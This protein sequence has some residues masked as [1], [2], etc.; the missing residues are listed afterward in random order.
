MNSG[1]KRQL[2][3]IG[4]ASMILVL[5]C[6]G[7]PSATT[8]GPEET[9]AVV[10]QPAGP[11]KADLVAL[12]KAKE[13]LDTAR[14]IVQDFNGP[15]YFPSEWE[16]A[17]AGY[18]G[19]PLTQEPATQDEARDL[20]NKINAVVQV[21]RSLADKTVKQYFQDA[22]G[23]T[24]TTFRALVEGGVLTMGPDLLKP[25]STLTAEARA[26]YQAGEAGDDKSY[27]SAKASYDKALEIYSVL[28]TGVAA[29]KVR[30]A[31]INL[32]LQ[33]AVRE[34]ALLEYTPV[35]LDIADA[36]GL[37]AIERYEGEDYPAAR[38]LAF[39]A[40]K[41]YEIIGTG[42][43][44]YKERLADI[45]EGI[46]RIAP[47]YL[48][49]V[50][51]KGIEG[52]AAFESG[53]EAA[54]DLALDA[55]NGY[56]AIGY[57]LDALLARF[58][59]IDAGI[60]VIAPEYLGAADAVALD[61][62]DVFESGDYALAKDKAV[63][64]I[65]AYAVIPAGI[66]AYRARGRAI[67]A[68]INAIAPE[69]LGTADQILIGALDD[70]DAGNY[71]G[72]GEGALKA[73]SAYSL[74]PPGIA[75]YQSRQAAIDAGIL[76][77]GPEYLDRADLVALGALEKYN[78]GD[79]AGAAQGVVAAQDAYL[80]IPKGIDAYKARIAALDA[81]I[82]SYGPGYLA[83]AD[84]IGLEAL[85]DYEAGD[86]VAAGEDAETAKAA[87]RVLS[88][89]IDAYKARVAAENSGI[90]TLAPE[91]LERA[92][93]V[94]FAALD[95]YDAGDYVGAAG[96]AGAAK[97]AYTIIPSGVDAYY[98]RGAALNAG[99]GTIGPEYLAI[100]DGTALSA[101]DAYNKGNFVAAGA[102][103]KRAGDAYGVLPIG[104]NAW[105]ARVAAINAGI[106]RLAPEY[107][108][109][110]DYV[111][112]KALD[113]YEG[114]QYTAAAEVALAAWTAYG[115]LP[116]GIEAYYARA[117]AVDAGIETLAPAY[118]AEA[119]WVA[120]DALDAYEAGKYGEATVLAEDAGTAYETLPIGVNAYKT[121]VAAVNA[122]VGQAAPGYLR[123]ADWVALIA[124]GNYEIGEFVAAK[125]D[126]V[127]AEAAYTA[128]S[129]GFD[130][131][132]ARE[133]ALGAGITTLGP[134]YLSAA[135]QVALVALDDYENGDYVPAV[136]SAGEAGNAYKALVG[137]ILAW[138]ARVAAVNA[139]IENYGPEYLYQADGEALKA[140]DQYDDGLYAA[141]GD[142]AGKVETAYTDLSV[143][144]N[145]Y[146]AR[147][148][149]LNA[150][151]AQVGPGYLNGVDATSLTALDQ[152]EKGDYA[153]AGESATKAYAAYTVLPV[154]VDA[155]NARVAAVNAGIGSYGPEYLAEA[156]Q[157]A[158]GGLDK[159][160]K[161]LYSDAGK[162]ALKAGDAYRALP[163]GVDAYK[164]RV[165]AIN[166]GIADYGPEFLAEA[167][168]VALVALYNFEDGK[169]V[170]AK[171]KAAEAEKAYGALVPAVDAY[172]G[173][174]A[175]VDAGIRVYG[176]DYLYRAD[177]QALGAI[178]QFE[179]GDYDGAK[180]SV[181]VAAEKY[182]PLA[183]G[184]QA[185]VSRV[186]DVNNG[187]LD[188]AP[189][190]LEPA[191]AIALNALDQ[192]EWEDFDKARD[193]AL[194]A[195]EVYDVIGKGLAAYRQRL[196]LGS[197]GELLA[198]EYLNAADQVGFQAL[199]EYERADYT[200][201]GKDAE[202]AGEMYSLI[203]FGIDVY[204]KRV[205]VVNKGILNYGA[206]YLTPSD[207]VALE[208]LDEY[209]AGNLAGAR[210]SAT[211]AGDMYDLVS[212]GMDVYQK[213]EGLVN[214]GILD[215][216]A[217]YLDV[218]DN[219]ALTAVDRYENKD[220]DGARKSAVQAESMYNLIGYGL[221]VYGERLALVKDG[222]LNVGPEYLAPADDV[223][224]TALDK[225]EAGDYAGAKQSA[226][227]AEEIYGIVGRGLD[228]YNERTAIFD[229]GFYDYDYQNI[230]KTDEIGLEALDDY[231][232]G[233]Y[234]AAIAKADVALSGYRKSYETGQEYHATDT[235]VDAE[236]Q[237]LAAMSVK[238]N[239]AVK[240][241]F[242]SANGLYEQAKASY[243]A[244]NWDEAADLYQQAANLYLVAGQRAEEKRVQAK[245]ALE[246]AQRRTQ[247][248]RETAI[249]AEETLRGGI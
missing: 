82:E 144:I 110:A 39:S 219:A 29:W 9:T 146:K 124:V 57:G 208:A 242:E 59:A 232:A 113:R 169:Y 206:E 109:I 14:K 243:Q 225:Y 12:E 98:A 151:I 23:K 78:A 16:A 120:L 181:K 139:G 220:V 112:L 158:L 214:K 227:Q 189:E 102:A 92:D 180:A 94:G 40:K 241:D 173:R 80:V 30:E 3:W 212:Y 93:G 6:G 191:D 133:K 137:G 48:Y 107:L 221:D 61:A 198:P 239:V 111:A 130:A 24:L 245:T 161:G 106:V 72:A 192:Y 171:G 79:F 126:A 71:A 249:K 186:A 244:R 184:V 168:T 128:L 10:S 154:G 164:E 69:Y 224:I 58:A 100:A 73:L 175:A 182:K 172:K 166:A 90:G 185:Y 143:G 114:G 157:V 194:E 101:L 240:Q 238:A 248:S 17:E 203:G 22:E 134:G 47:D 67:Q 226:A 64:T 20:T 51:E 11:E 118:L 177:L 2:W 223:A 197:V 38:E 116:I 163:V 91:Y 205:A 95:A 46:L 178:N 88:L 153:A 45:D 234:I 176:P 77:Y 199:D 222:I 81:G 15:G 54:A 84:E 135:D 165:A 193:S 103:V 217:E 233:D 174:I 18:K 63:N 136:E 122:G 26:Q 89:G 170:E 33:L 141:A 190:Y 34:P 187:I 68:G 183:P 215:Y 43:N 121:R 156:D 149:A 76:A 236:K 138:N 66:A 55:W 25:A 31:D 209:D 152:Y 50:D 155:W 42:L 147:V 8:P 142:S 65:A 83:E 1:K 211:K 96:Y 21:Y 204:G 115:A 36:E 235:G 32:G 13:G 200:A 35:Y 19:L 125:E 123:Q 202:K 231:S 56:V 167:D 132:L 119:D 246:E 210:S 228:A 108:D 52:L 104:V 99:I 159:Y 148:T 28:E 207:E 196:A 188:Y 97:M 127:K 195:K 75:A 41:L 87:Y 74:I 62:L 237:R 162:D 86:Y 140:L 44:A 201:A 85:N 4:I 60:E 129:V 49:A 216:G 27:Y 105:K 179:A 5:S 117:A 218:A 213:R 131:Y 37:K 7:T 53:D 229:R 150:G 160:E 230:D 70:Y 247:E 145:A